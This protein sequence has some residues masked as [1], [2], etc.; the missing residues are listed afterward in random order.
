MPTENGPLELRGHIEVVAPSGD[1]L[2]EADE[3]WLCRCGRSKSKPFCDGSHRNG[4]RSRAP[5]V[6]AERDEAESPD[7]FAPN[8]QVA[9]TAP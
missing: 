7:A 4:F 6:P 8:P 1:P 3:L 2:A 5:E 9:P